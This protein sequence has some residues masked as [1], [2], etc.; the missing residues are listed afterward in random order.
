[1][2]IISALAGQALACLAWSTASLLSG[3]LVFSYSL[4]HR[5]LVPIIILGAF[6]LSTLPFSP[7]WQAAALFNSPQELPGGNLL[8]FVYIVC[9]LLIQAMLLAGLVRCLVKDII[10]PSETMTIH[11]E[12]WVW[13]VYPIGLIIDVGAHLLAGWFMLPDVKGLPVIAWIVGPLT[14]LISRLILVL[15]LRFA[16]FSKDFER[17]GNSTF[18]KRIFSNEWLYNLIWRIYQIITRIL[19]ISSTV[20]EGEGGILWALVLFALIFVFLQR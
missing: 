18:W 7:T 5:Y 12:R 19:T 8:N 1:M 10:P 15:T 9:F 2:V 17:L 4:R 16:G 20:L 14:V 13:V 6:N 3:G 11:V